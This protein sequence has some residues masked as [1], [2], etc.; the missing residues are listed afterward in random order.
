VCVGGCSPPA[1]LLVFDAE[2]APLLQRLFGNWVIVDCERTGERVVRDW[3]LN[4]I[5]RD[6]IQMKKVSPLAEYDDIFPLWPSRHVSRDNFAAGTG[7][8]RRTSSSRSSHSISTLLAA[9]RSS[10]LS[11]RSPERYAAMDRSQRIET[12]TAFHVEKV[13]R[14][15]EAQ[16]RVRSLAQKKDALQTKLDEINGQ[17]RVVRSISACAVI[18]R[19]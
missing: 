11:P 19:A 5:T 4:A 12:L 15:L 18:H 3:E 10:P 14:E 9:L 7:P 17:L 1:D 13:H 2:F 8:R 6:G 16:Q